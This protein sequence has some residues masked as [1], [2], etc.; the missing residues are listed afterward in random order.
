MLQNVNEIKS[1]LY[2]DEDFLFI[3]IDEFFIFPF[4]VVEFHQSYSQEF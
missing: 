4:N 1:I 2:F 3:S